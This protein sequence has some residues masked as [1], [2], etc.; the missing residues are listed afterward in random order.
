MAVRRKPAPGPDEEQVDY[1]PAGFVWITHPDLEDSK[2]SVPEALVEHHALRGWVLAD[3]PAP[4]ADE[5]TTVAS[6]DDPDLSP[7][8]D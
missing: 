6:T 1:L 7:Q 8:E 5:E 3:S 4:V 2:A